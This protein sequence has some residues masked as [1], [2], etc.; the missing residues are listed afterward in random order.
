MFHGWITPEKPPIQNA[1]YV[2]LGCGSLNPFG[3]LFLF[4]MLGA[5]RGV[6]VDLDPIQDEK[7]ALSA[8]ADLVAFMLIDPHRILA[9]YPIA[10]QSILDNIAS[11]DLAKLGS[12]DHDG[13]DR[14]R[15][16][17][18]QE[19][20]HSL[21]LEDSE[22][23][24]VYSNSFL[25]H[26]SRAEAGVAELSRITRPGGMGIHNIDLS[27]HRRYGDSSHHMLAF[28]QDDSGEELV[29]ESNRLRLPDFVRMFEHQGFDVL[30]TRVY[31]SADMSEELRSTFIEP[32]RSMNL[33]DLE[34]AGVVIVTRKR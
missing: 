9:D 18:R 7:A 19:T 14:D 33:A 29:G 1:T 10:R 26:I 16:S 15:L 21:S 20:V 6:A 13:V 3:T 12:G 17:F 2:E 25:E 24:V 5:R 28:L 27:D 11:F 34:A 31:H 23:D 4:L 32:F 8:L 30:A 22:A